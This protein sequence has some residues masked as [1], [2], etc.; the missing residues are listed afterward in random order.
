MYIYDNDDIFNAINN[1]AD[2]YADVED[3]NDDS[4][5]DDDK[6][7]DQSDKDFVYCVFIMMTEV[8]KMMLM[9]MLF[10]CCRWCRTG[11]LWLRC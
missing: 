3:E 9:M 10:C 4:D 7:E 1:D 8:I 5:N 6:V 2:I 11:S